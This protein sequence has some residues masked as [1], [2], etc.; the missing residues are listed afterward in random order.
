MIYGLLIVAL[1]CL[2]ALL[3]FGR[4][5][6]GTCCG[7]GAN[8]TVQI[9]WCDSTKI[10]G[11]SG[12]AVTV[13]QNNSG[14]AV[15]ASGT[16]DSSGQFEWTAP[17]TG[18]YYFS[19]V[20]PSGYLT[21]PTTQHITVTGS[22][23]SPNKA[24]LL[25]YPDQLTLTDA[26]VG[27]VTLYP[28]G[29][30]SIAGSGSSL[31]Y[32]G[33][34]VFNY[35]AACGCAAGSVELQYAYNPCISASFDRVFAWCPNNYPTDPDA[36]P[37]TA[38][39][40]FQSITSTNLTGVGPEQATCYPV[41]ESWRV[42]V[43]RRRWGILQR[44]RELRDVQRRTHDYP[45]M[46]LTEALDIVVSRTRH[47]RYR[48]LCSD[49]NPDEFSRERYRAIVMSMAATQTTDGGLPSLFTQAANLAGAVGRVV[50]AVATGQAV[51]VTPEE[52]DQRGRCVRPART[53]WAIGASC[54]G[55]AS[56][57]RSSWPLSAARSAN[58]RGSNHD[59]DD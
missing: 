59:D 2:L 47:E 54:A 9:W 35:G 41:N 20:V 58:G 50:K 32:I 33:S 26:V 56:G 5:G 13:Q 37:D 36:C 19:A 40:N 53:L 28:Y 46:T 29:T 30:L 7:C 43:R 18:T 12:I 10:C 31:N 55:V 6:L 1:V 16:T 21:T 51:K 14:G 52:R 39:S 48:W 42:S 4:F 38:G 25:V 57:Q 15:V 3:P 44:V 24:L 45:V 23:A 34:V 22:T 49:E 27:A 17:S 11:F 8:H